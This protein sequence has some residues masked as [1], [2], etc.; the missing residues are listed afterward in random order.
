[1]KIKVS[2]A[3]AA[4][5]GAHRCASGSI[6]A[7]AARINDLQNQ[8]KVKTNLTMSEMVSVC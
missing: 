8:I 7:H 5:P 4:S 1:M 3:W 6:G 2:A